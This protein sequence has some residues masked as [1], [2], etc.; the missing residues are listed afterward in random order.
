MANSPEPQGDLRGWGIYALAAQQDPYGAWA[1]LRSESPV[2]DAGDGVFLVTSWELVD[3]ALRDPSLLAGRGVAESLDRANPPPIDAPSLW[4]MSLDGPAHTRARNLIRRP[5]AA[6]R[7]MALRPLIESIAAPLVSGFLLDARKAP[8]DFYRRVAL[9]IP[10]Q[11]MRSL[12]EIPQPLWRE[13]VHALFAADAQADSAAILGDL[14]RFFADIESPSGL[15]RAL[16]EPDEEGNRLRSDEVIA[17]AS[18][19]VMAGIDTTAGLIANTVLELVRNPDVFDQLRIDPARVPEAVEETLRHEP[20]ALSCSRFAPQA[21]AL[22]KVEIPPESHLLLCIGAANRDP[23]Q[24]DDPDAFRLGRDL[25]GLV[26]FGGGR[27][28]CLGAALARLEAAVA[29]EALVESAARLDLAAPVQWRTDNPTVRLPE[30]FELRL[31]Q[32]GHE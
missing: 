30:T 10:S 12:F 16:H 7:V 20:P 28:F 23:K 21:F 6:R 13:R 1:E 8:V 4:L 24:Y 26:T 14:V 5:F 32:E 3:Q 11:V 22:G 25:S 18:L 29:V 9:E 27:H 17:N 19:M 2:L 31:V 15:L